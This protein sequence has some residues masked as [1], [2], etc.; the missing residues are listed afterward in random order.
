[1][2]DK[3]TIPHPGAPMSDA[4]ET[5]PH[6]LTGE[7]ALWC[8]DCESDAV[9]ARRTPSLLPVAP[10]PPRRQCSAIEED[11]GRQCIDF[12]KHAGPH[13]APLGAETYVAWEGDARAVGSESYALAALILRS[14]TAPAPETP[15]G[16]AAIARKTIKEVRAIGQHYRDDWSNF[17]GR[18]LRAQL[19]QATDGLERAAAEETATA[20][21]S[22]APREPD[23]HPLCPRCTGGTL[24]ETFC[25]KCEWPRP[26]PDPND[27]KDGE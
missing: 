13:R 15:R 4:P 14:T 26:L 25:P 27:S 8:L 24:L 12:E 21:P 9:T 10:E 3:S 2:N 23:P 19:I 16:L 20:L 17:D 7:A 18:T 1:M 11:T 22:A 5:C 6:G